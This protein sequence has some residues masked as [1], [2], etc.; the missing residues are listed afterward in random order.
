[1]LSISTAP[2]AQQIAA[3]KKQ[4]GGVYALEVAEHTAYVRPPQPADLTRAHQG[5]GGDS[6][7][8]HETLLE[9][10]WLAGPAVLQTDEGLRLSAACAMG[11]VVAELLPDYKKQIAA[12]R[13][14]G[15]R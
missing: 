9:N 8:M 6:L 11:Q 5:S 4:Y 14:G 7:K 12:R 2:G 15:K 3:W 1:M 10:C 13:P